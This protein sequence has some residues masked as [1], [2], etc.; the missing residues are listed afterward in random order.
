MDNRRKEKARLP[1]YDELLKE[2]GIVGELIKNFSMDR[3]N[4]SI[5]QHEEQVRI[6]RSALKRLDADQKTFINLS[7]FTDNEVVTS[8]LTQIA[9]QL[10]DAL[11]KINTLK[12]AYEKSLGLILSLYKEKTAINDRNYNLGMN[13]SDSRQARIITAGQE[14]T[15]ENIWKSLVAL[16]K[17]RNMT[18]LDYEEDIHPE[19]VKEYD[20]V[21]AQSQQVREKIKKERVEEVQSAPHTEQ[22]NEV[23][24]WVTNKSLKETL[25]WKPTPKVESSASTTNSTH[26]NTSSYSPL[27][28][29]GK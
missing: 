23:D 2:S 3:Y 5:D 13:I 27:N 24:K 11:E 14:A 8:A 20:A 4:T 15:L 9:S 16:D 18:I 21:L 26:N 10:N 28:P 29:S 19:I 25:M 17:S 22:K 12:Q 1:G 6:L 7:L